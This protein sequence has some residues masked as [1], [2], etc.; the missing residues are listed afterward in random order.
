MPELRKDPIIGRWVIISTERAMRPDDFVGA[1]GDFRRGFCPFCYGNEDR[2][3]PE[4]L[5]Y[6]KGQPDTPGWTLRAVPNKFPA[7]QVEGDLDRRGEGMFDKMNG[8]G[9]HEVIIETPEHNLQLADL[10]Q[11]RVEDVI[12]SYR[13]RFVDLKKD[14]RFQYILIFKNHG[15]AAGATLEHSHSQL[16]ALPIIPKRVSEEIEGAKRYFSYKERCVYC[17]IIRQEMDTG[18]RVIHENKSFISMAPFCPRFPFETWI[19]PKTH[20]AGFEDS[21]RE[22]VKQLAQ[23]LKNTLMRMNKSL[24][25]PPYNF[26]IHTSPI[27]NKSQIYYHWHIEIMPKL[28]KVAGF[29]WGTGFYI[30]PTSPEESAKFMREVEI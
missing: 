17:D 6:R 20:E 8:I 5:A 25:D 18:A 10:P 16:I 11:D 30:N 7:L 29:E 14:K 23:I 26:L 2:T 3:P 24:N 19:V 15:R 1:S 4:V 13:D 27:E 22:E 28:T 9:A 21:S 12:W